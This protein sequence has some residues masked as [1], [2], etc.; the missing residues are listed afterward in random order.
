MKRL[1]NVQ[2]E[3]ESILDIKLRRGRNA[4]VVD[5]RGRVAR[6][7]LLCR[8][9][10]GEEVCVDISDEGASTVRPV[11]KIVG[12]INLYHPKNR[13]DARMTVDT[14]MFLLGDYASQATDIS[15]SFKVRPMGMDTAV[16][17][18]RSMDPG[19]KILQ[20]RAIRETFHS[21]VVYPDLVLKLTEY[22]DMQLQAQVTDFTFYEGQ[23]RTCAEL[24][25]SGMVWWEAS[26]SSLKAD[27]LMASR[28]QQ[29]LGE[30]ATWTSEEVASNDTIGS[31][32]TLAD[33]MV[34]RMNHIGNT[35]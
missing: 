30:L 5:P 24:A 9:E 29:E 18:L 7:E 4:F 27:T 26:L 2:A 21:S 15:K 20:G 25:P 6:F 17:S 8:I 32:L 33:D 12:G 19:L 1:T 35:C 34:L 10:S 3:A 14:S 31:M 22:R 28:S 13:W 23:I 11:R 16:V